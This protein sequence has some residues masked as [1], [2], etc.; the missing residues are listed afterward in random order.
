MRFAMQKTLFLIVLL[1]VIR[2]PGRADTDTIDLENRTYTPWHYRVRTPQGPFSDWRKVLPGATMQYSDHP[3]LL[4]EIW[5]DAEHS[6]KYDIRRGC[7]YA[8]YRSKPGA[9][10]EAMECLGPGPIKPSLPGSPPADASSGETCFAPLS[11]F[12]AQCKELKQP[13]RLSLKRLAAECAEAQKTGGALP[14]EL[15]YLHGFTWFVGYLVDDANRDVIL[16]GIKDPTRPPVDID[17]LATAIKAAYSDSVPR[18]SLDPHPDPDFQKSVVEGVPW[19]TRWAEVMIRADYDMKKL[20]LGQMDPAIDGFKSSTQHFD[21]VL[22][23]LGFVGEGQSGNGGGKT[24][25]FKDRWWF[26]FDSQVP[27]AVADDAGKVVYLH[28]NPV[29]VS[30]EALVNGSYGSGQTATSARRFAE[31]FTKHMVTLGKHYPNIAE[32]LAMY[33]LYDLMRHLRLASQA[34]PP[35]MDYWLRTYEHPYEGPPAAMPTLAVT[36]RIRE[37]VQGGY[38]TH[39]WDIRGGVVMQ[40]GITPQSMKRAIRP[41]GLWSAAEAS[42]TP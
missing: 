33:R 7:T 11:K 23:T 18:C 27:R 9:A 19:K 36:R 26:N 1:A 12:I 3:Q 30:T 29:R 21:D 8:Y 42:A 5:Y 32:L 24:R 39:R 2:T 37:R 16:L 40:L 14:V 41:A 4:I 20:I 17:C 13:Y 15:R 31:D 6:A 28:R 25:N 22:S 34:V 38:E 10:P 35:D